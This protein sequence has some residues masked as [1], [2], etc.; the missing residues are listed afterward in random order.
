MKDTARHRGMRNL[1]ARQLSE[2]P[3]YPISDEKVLQAIR[4]I[5]RHL[6]LDSIFEE[7]AY[8]DIAFPISA[9]QTISRPHTVA[10]QTELLQV[11]QGQKVLEI[12]TGSGYQSAVLVFLK[13]D[14]YT[15]ERQQELFKKTKLLLE[16]MG[17]IPK[18][19]IFGDGYKGYVEQAP[20]DRILV[21]AGAPEVPM[22]LL[23]QL[24]IGGRLVIPIGKGEQIMTVFTRLSPNE[25]NKEEYGTFGFVPMLENVQAKIR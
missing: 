17:Y 5:P 6:F 15:I 23:A 14:L 8:Q 13:V 20:Y 9:D 16:K 18:K 21:T 25:F 22:E 3:H 1:L 4:T 24:K 2:R 12:G 10:F 19:M 7:K 11:R